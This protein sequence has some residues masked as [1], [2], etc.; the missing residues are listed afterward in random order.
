[1]QDFW[2]DG[3]GAMVWERWFGSDGLGARGSVRAPN[4]AIC[5][6]DPYSSLHPPTT[7]VPTALAIAFLAFA[8]VDDSLD[9][10]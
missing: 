1:M 2:A 5:H 8:L 4:F 10:Q 7:V 9:V 3:L 6:R